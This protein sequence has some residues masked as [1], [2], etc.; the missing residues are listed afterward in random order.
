MKA[1]G[2]RTSKG[3]GFVLEWGFLSL[4]VTGDLYK[5]VLFLF[6]LD[7]AVEV[8]LPDFIESKSSHRTTG[9]ADSKAQKIFKVD[10][11]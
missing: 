7:A 4:T 8:V 6:S 10:F 9:E 5:L 11:I 3:L 1:I 2:L